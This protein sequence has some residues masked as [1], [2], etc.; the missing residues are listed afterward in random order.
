MAVAS[1][2]K[3]T[4]NELNDDTI[5]KKK[6]FYSN[7]V[8]SWQ[9]PGCKDFVTIR[10]VNSDGTRAKTT[11]QIC[12]LTVSLEEVYHHFMTVNPNMKVGL[13]KF[14]DLRPPNIKLFFSGNLP[15]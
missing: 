8:I 9:T 2:K 3:K 13:N 4:K 10:T 15:K 14:C 5:A 6:Y 12:Y 1:P 11:E 7:N